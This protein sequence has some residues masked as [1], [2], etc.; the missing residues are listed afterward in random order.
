M[1]A[2]PDDFLEE[3]PLSLPPEDEAVERAL[4]RAF[5][6]SG[7]GSDLDWQ[8]VNCGLWHGNT[9]TRCEC[10]FE[11]EQD[12]LSKVRGETNRLSSR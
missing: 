5:G 1:L 6:S 8:C 9:E 11:A 7:H 2:M 10:G 3:E 12:P 4:R